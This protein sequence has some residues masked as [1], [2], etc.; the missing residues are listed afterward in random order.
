MGLVTSS[1]NV[2]QC[3]PLPLTYPSTQFPRKA[4]GRRVLIQTSS[5]PVATDFFYLTGFHEP[6]SV[7]VLGKYLSSLS[8]GVRG[9][10]TGSVLRADLNTIDPYPTRS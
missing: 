9:R 7:L 2:S 4:P 6:D 5:F 10:H 8:G 1:G 3:L